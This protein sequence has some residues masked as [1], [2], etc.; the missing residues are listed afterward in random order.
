MTAESP[1]RRGHAL[2]ILLI[3]V[4][5]AS[6]GTGYLLR[7]SWTRWRAERLRA[8]SAREIVDAY[9]QLW[10]E[11]PDTW[12]ANRWLG[13][14]TLQNPNDVWVIQEIITEV[15]PDFVV[16]TGTAF[17]GSAAL[18]AMILDQVNPEGRVITID[19]ARLVSTRTLPEV[20]RRK[21]DFLV[22]SSTAPEIV[23]EVTRRVKGRRTIVI[24]D[25]DHS[26][27]H[28]LAELKAY[29]PLVGVGSYLIVQD[30]DINGHPVLKDAGPGPMEAVEEF[31]RGNAAFRS[32]RSRER[33]LFTVLPKGYLKRVA[34]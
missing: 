8:R 4:A 19:I 32:D 30:T 10:Y 29:S 21:V 12:R 7:D 14:A 9:H 31:L 5:A 20:A 26:R 13:I 28:V 27:D 1:S 11:S 3:A 33:L 24:L 23:A 15:R 34:S 2:R 18:W 16:E 25:S 22:G 17:G 6:L